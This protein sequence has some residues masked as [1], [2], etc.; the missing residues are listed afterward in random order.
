M[1][2]ATVDGLRTH[3]EIHGDGPPLLMYSP[4]GFDASLDKWTALGVYGR[5]EMLKQLSQ[6]FRCIVFDR[7]E[8]GESSG[9]IENIRWQHYIAQGHGLL[10]EL[11]IDR[12]FLLG[13]CMGCCPV[14]AHAVAWPESVAGM[15]LYWP[16]G[17]ARFRIRAEQ[18]FATHLAEVARSGLSG[19]VELALQTSEG[20]GKDPR[21]GPWAP[22]IRNDKE[23]AEQYSQFNVEHYRL[24]VTAMARTLVDRD[25]VAGAEPEDLLRL[26]MPTLIVPGNDI[27]HAVSAARY[28]QECLPNADYWDIAPDDQLA[29][30]VPPRLI[31]FLSGIDV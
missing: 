24:I 4:G 10:R 9:R 20:F 31:E 6:R 11:D 15:I 25:S 14:L 26:E 13:G 27:A 17:G 7:R 3:Y 18:R 2:F 22:V 21:V 8:T 30:N 29:G 5:T 16:V 28:L 23:F 19:I 1:A 12:A